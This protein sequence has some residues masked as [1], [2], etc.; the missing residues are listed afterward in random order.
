MK[1]RKFPR[2]Q[3]SNTKRWKVA[4][5]RKLRDKFGRLNVLLVEIPGREHQKQRQRT[6]SKKEELGF[7]SQRGLLSSQQNDEQDL[8]KTHDC[9][10][11]GPW[12]LRD[13]TKSLQKIKDQESK[14]H[15][16]LCNS[17]GRTSS[18]FR[19]KMSSL[20]IYNQLNYESHVRVEFRYFR[21]E[22][23]QKMYLSCHTFHETVRS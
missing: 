23:S 12:G 7:L 4:E 17:L 5:R 11:S 13:N 20:D 3:N 8:P 14:W 9:N 2:K 15:C 6:S 10:I 16:I 1:L 21:F 19:R 22:R 18:K